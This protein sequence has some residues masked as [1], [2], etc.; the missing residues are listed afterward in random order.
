MTNGA[1]SI[2][3]SGIITIYI[4]DGNFSN[5][6]NVGIETTTLSYTII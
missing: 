2:N 4:I 3:T 1:I 5:S 6:S